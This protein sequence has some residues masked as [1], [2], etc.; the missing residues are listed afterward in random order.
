MI[1]KNLRGYLPVYCRASIKYLYR[2][3]RKIEI[4][5]EWPD[6]HQVKDEASNTKEMVTKVKKHVR[7][8]MEVSNG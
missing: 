5:M 3:G 7:A 6:G 2:L 1:D 8:R 4:V